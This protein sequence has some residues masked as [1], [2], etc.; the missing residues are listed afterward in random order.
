MNKK[1]R[2]IE[3]LNKISNGM[4]IPKKIYF[5]GYNYELQREEKNT[6]YY[7]SLYGANF[8]RLTMDFSIL[9]SLNDYVEYE[10]EETAQ[11]LKD[12]K[13]N[14]IGN[15]EILAHILTIEEILKQVYKIKGYQVDEVLECMRKHIEKCKKKG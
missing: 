15:E 13:I 7:R 11:T 1:I 10:E 9:D 8:I 14:M 12:F 4:E 3:L 6:G 2:I 5:N